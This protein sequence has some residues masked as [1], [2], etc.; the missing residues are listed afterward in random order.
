MNNLRSCILSL[1]V[2]SDSKKTRDSNEWLWS[3]V[4]RPSLYITHS[5]LNLVDQTQPV[6][7]AVLG[8]LSLAAE[9]EYTHQ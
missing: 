1:R 8:D 5:S 7:K 6:F 3:S 2:E 9:L 4:N